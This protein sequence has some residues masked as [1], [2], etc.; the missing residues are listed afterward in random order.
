MK[1]DGQTLGE[2]FCR[3]LIDA[4]PDAQAR[5]I[6]VMQLG[7]FSGKTIYLPAQKKNKR[8]AEVASSLLKNEMTSA[9]AALIIH[10][11]FGVTM[12]QAQRDVKQANT[13]GKK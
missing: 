12:R 5:V 3:T 4:M 2:V 11:R 9:E 6:L 1:L 10:E 8:R 7:R 13:I